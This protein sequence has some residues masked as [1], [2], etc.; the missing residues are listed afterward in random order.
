[1]SADT[2]P[3][4]ESSLHSEVL[5][6]LRTKIIEGQFNAGERIPER[7][8]CET[9]KISRTPLREAMKVL[10]A[11]GLIELLPNRG[12]RVPVLT[13]QELSDLFDIMGG[14]ESMAG[15]IACERITDA[16]VLEIE[17]LHYEMYGHYMRRNLPE[18]FRCNQA[19]HSAI[20]D[21]TRNRALASLH[22]SYST[23]LQRARFAANQSNSYD[24]WAQAMREHE[25][26]L[27]CLKRR[28]S[29][30]LGDVLFCHLRN[31]SRASDAIAQ[32]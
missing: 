22:Q 27:D 7:E 9:L 6:S 11:E 14:I 17:T 18:Y 16:E 20:V 26:I 25:T 28:D 15:R 31:K 4:E 19:I 29:A 13:G 32:N 2:L 23:R 30:A 10:A 5:N 24:R 3:T 21:A 12:A 1:M 8:L